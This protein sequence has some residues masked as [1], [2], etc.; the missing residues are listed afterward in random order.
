MNI[1]YKSFAAGEIDAYKTIE[2][3]SLGID[4]LTGALRAINLDKTLLTLP[5][6]IGSGILNAE[7]RI[8]AAVVL[9]IPGKDS[10]KSISFGHNN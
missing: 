4:D 2:A 8:L 10:Q 6:N 1:A 7:E 5:S 3:L 9:P